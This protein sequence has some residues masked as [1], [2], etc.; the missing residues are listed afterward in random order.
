MCPNWLCSLL[1]LAAYTGVNCE[2][3]PEPC[4]ARDDCSGHLECLGPVEF[5]CLGFWSGDDCRI[6]NYTGPELVDPECP[7]AFGCFD[8]GHCFD[9]A[10]CCDPGYTGERCNSE[11]LECLSGPCGDGGLCRDLIN[12][13]E[14]DCFEGMRK[15]FC[16][17]FS[18]KLCLYLRPQLPLLVQL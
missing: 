7:D 2:N 8:N 14:C 1:S 3:G 15:D 17:P 10:C 11:I 4:V 12:S 16:F 9:G 5:E 13:Y 18:I 6:R